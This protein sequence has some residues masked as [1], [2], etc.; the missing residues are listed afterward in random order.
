MLLV[1][2]LLGYVIRLVCLCLIV[3]QPSCYA[4][5]FQS[6]TQDTPTAA[7]C[8]YWCGSSGTRLDT[9]GS[10][11]LLGNSCSHWICPTAP[12]KSFVF[13]GVSV[14]LTNHYIGRKHRLKNGCSFHPAVLQLL[15]LGKWVHPTK[16]RWQQKKIFQIGWQSIPGQ[17]QTFAYYGQYS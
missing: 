14:P 17:I 3:H 10:L 13:M 12:G 15:T 9:K 6:Q 8:T 2:F 11:C 1:I 4:S 5:R 16:Y 7:C